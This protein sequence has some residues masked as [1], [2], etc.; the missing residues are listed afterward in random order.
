MYRRPRKLTTKLVTAGCA[1]A[2]ALVAPARLVGKVT[3]TVLTIA[4]LIL[5]FVK[6]RDDL[7]KGAQALNLDIEIPPF[8]ITTKIEI[9]LDP[10]Q[11]ARII[12]AIRE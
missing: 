9:S 6:Y 11:E 10:A 3:V 2:K 5:G 4:T 8:E 12:Q 1:A 7:T